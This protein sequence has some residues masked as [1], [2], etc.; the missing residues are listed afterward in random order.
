M[1]VE[2][3]QAFLPKIN[4][5]VLFLENGSRKV[6]LTLKGCLRLILEVVMAFAI[7]VLFIR[8]YLDRTTIT[9]SAVPTFPRKTY[10][11]VENTRYLHDEMFASKD[12][13]LHTL[14][15]WIELSADGRGYIKINDSE[16][17][18]LGQPYEMKVN[19]SYS[20]PVYMVSVFHQ[21][22]CLSYLVQTYQT[23]FDGT[24]LTKEVAHHAAHCFDYIRQS[25]MCAADTSLEGKTDAGPGWGSKHEC[26]DYDLLL[27]WANKHT[28]YKY[29]TNMPAEAV[30]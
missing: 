29:R 16:Y 19:S 12:E 7:V 23:A 15:N 5:D 10:T 3:Q 11:F 24:N 28:V 14:H 21:L 25:I 22:H 8:H 2:D 18:N 26:T 6:M 30:L 27:S 20:E 17:F 9:P 13:T 1:D 4:E